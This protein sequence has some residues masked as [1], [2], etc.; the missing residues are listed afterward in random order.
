MPDQ[1]PYTHVR[2][3]LHDDGN[4]NQRYE[5]RVSTFVQFDSNAGRRVIS[6][7]PTKKQAEEVAKQIARSER[8]RTGAPTWP[9]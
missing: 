8:V 4:L 1:K 6:G 9:K 7:H 3:I 2:L 5:I